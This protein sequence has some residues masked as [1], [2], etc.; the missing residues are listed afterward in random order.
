MESTISLVLLYLV[1]VWINFTLWL[2][3][4]DKLASRSLIQQIKSIQPR[5]SSALLIFFF[6]KL[7]ISRPF[8]Y[9][10]RYASRIYAYQKNLMRYSE[11]FR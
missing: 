1:I 6:V 11:L 9:V 4:F 7:A 10:I 3:C 2:K 5:V 8:S